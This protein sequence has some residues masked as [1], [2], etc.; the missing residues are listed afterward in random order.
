MARLD[1][2]WLTEGKSIITLALPMIFLTL[3]PY[4]ANSQMQ[5]LHDHTLAE[6][7]NQRN[8][9]EGVAQIATG[10]GPEYVQVD[11]LRA[12]VYVTN[13]V[14]N[15]VSVI[16]GDDNINVKDIPVGKMPSRLTIDP[17]R[18]IIYVLNL[19]ND[20]V[21]VVDGDSNLK[22]KDIPVGFGPYDSDIDFPPSYVYVV[23]FASDT[24]SVIN[25]T[26]NNR[27][28]EIPVGDEP[29]NV[30]S[31]G[32]Y[33]Y[34]TNSGDGTVSVID[35]GNYNKIKDI[36]V[37]IHP[38]VIGGFI[39]DP[40]VSRGGVLVPTILEENRYMYV[41]GH[42]SVSVIDIINNE[43][44]K[45]IPVANGNYADIYDMKIDQSTK[46]VYA[47]NRYSD[48]VSVINGTGFTK[49]KDI[50]VGVNP[51]D[52]EIGKDA[53]IELPATVY[54][55][56]HD[57]DTVSVING[58]GFTKIKDIPVGDAPSD[59][60]VDDVTHTIYVANTASGGISVIDGISNEVVAGIQVMI[61][62]INAGHIS[63]NNVETPTNQYFYV[64]S[65]T[66]CTAIPNQDFAFTDWIENFDNNS[67]RI[68]STS[69][70]RYSFFSP[71][72]EILGWVGANDTSATMNITAFGDFTA[73]FKQLPPPIPSEYITIIFTV[74]I[75]S[76]G[77]SV[78]IPHFIKYNSKR[79][80]TKNV[81]GFHRQI[82]ALDEDKRLN[83]KDTKLLD[84][85]KKN[86]SSAYSLGKFNKDYYDNLNNEISIVYKKI[87]SKQIEL[88]IC[89]TN[90]EDKIKFSNKIQTDIHNAFSDGKLNENHYTILKNQLAEIQSS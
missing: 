3:F 20:T 36:P 45:D 74:I 90:K 58:T 30:A 52:I 84:K 70:L 46:T 25:T 41:G 40:T 89:L 15:T 1:S 21:S 48:T 51:V 16:D 35:K 38:S 26:T 72:L 44:I 78:L 34:V 54:V 5:T 18:N 65:G 28:K 43:K 10:E 24:I 29:T 59:I 88:L 6:I 81:N 9:S 83:E 2:C 14:S 87:Y 77:G 86:I 60:A 55:A 23:N 4:S 33:V 11:T 56:N 53:S 37:G 80:E 22:V 75:G 50:P 62:P 79:K 31:L 73:N 42:Y 27:I 85:V 63:C 39:I 64:S 13:K 47:A 66:R 19:N 8:Q 17:L 32:K 69:Q 71:L 68:I 67:T 61:N 7:A 12:R 76:V 82:A 49:I 57:S